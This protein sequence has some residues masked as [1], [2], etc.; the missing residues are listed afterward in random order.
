VGDE[1]KIEAN[2]QREPTSEEVKF[3]IFGA[4][5]KKFLNDYT[6][7]NPP[8]PLLLPSPP[9]PAPS[10]PRSST[11]KKPT[12]NKRFKSPNKDPLSAYK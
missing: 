10:K 6:M 4:L 1:I 7:W 8:L 11:P 9:P 3:L 2:Q 12:P 5:R